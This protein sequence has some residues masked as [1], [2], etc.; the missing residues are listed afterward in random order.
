MAVVQFETTE[1][2]GAL[3][4]G[5][6]LAEYTVVGRLGSGRRAS[7]YRV[8]HDHGSTHAMKVLDRRGRAVHAELARL[9]RDQ[10]RIDHP[11]LLPFVDLASD[12]G[13]TALIT[14]FVEGPTLADWLIRH[15]PGLDERLRVF[16][17]MLDGLHAAHLAGIVHGDLTPRN[18]LI[19]MGRRPSPRIG[20]FGLARVLGV[21]R[22]AYKAP[23]H[24][25]DMRSD[26]YALGVLLHEIVTGAVPDAR[27][28]RS[29]ALVRDPRMALAI[30]SCTA[31]DRS[32]RPADVPA[33]LALLDQKPRRWLN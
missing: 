18:I 29:D 14:D 13:R 32:E 4:P 16:R 5:A 3:F 20:D 11:G 6:R 17:L 8:V 12:A 9:A 25:L 15:R 27:A 26:V 33:L 24:L 30:R 10:D 7:V 22:S 28:G 1:P 19:G 21:S 23:E 31:R 2:T